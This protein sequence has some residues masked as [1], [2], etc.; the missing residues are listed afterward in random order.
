MAAPLPSSML[1]LATCVPI[2]RIAPGRTRN[3]SLTTCWRSQIHRKKPN[4]KPM[5]HR[6]ARA[7][8]RKS[9]V[10]SAVE[11]RLRPAERANGPVRPHHW[12]RPSPNRNRRGEPRLRSGRSGS[13]LRP[14]QREQGNR[15]P[16]ARCS[17]DASGAPAA[18]IPETKAAAHPACNCNYSN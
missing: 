14:H 18:S 8:A 7:N 17:V 15:N 6:T 9:A 3:S 12:H 13:S 1:P 10:C 11:Y 4:G 5:P 2:P 16:G